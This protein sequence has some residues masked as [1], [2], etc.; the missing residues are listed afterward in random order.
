M[1]RGLADSA[2]KNV[3]N[4]CMF[5]RRNAS[6]VAEGPEHSLV[7]CQVLRALLRSTSLMLRGRTPY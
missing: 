2:F 6:E 5:L 4:D 1:I 7:R 3:S